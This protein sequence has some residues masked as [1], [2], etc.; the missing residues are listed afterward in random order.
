MCR[1]F[2]F[3]IVLMLCG[4]PG[5]AFG[6]GDGPNPILT[7]T[8]NIVL[9]NAN[10]IVV[11]TDSNQTRRLEN[12]EPRIAISF[13]SGRT[14]ILTYLSSSKPRQNTPLCARD[15]IKARLA[16][17]PKKLSAL[18]RKRAQTGKSTDPN[19]WLGRCFGWL[20]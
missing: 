20:S 10:G 1:E 15:T 2:T 16:L 17:T 7:G 6:G 13:S 9:A 19:Q 8:V 18:F 12:G 11:L 14:P 4:F 5:V 3:R